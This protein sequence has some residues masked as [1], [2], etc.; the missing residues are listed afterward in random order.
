MACDVA[1]ILSTTMIHKDLILT[2]RDDREKAS[3]NQTHALP[4]TVGGFDLRGDL[5][6]KRSKPENVMAHALN[7]MTHSHGD[8]GVQSS[9]PTP[10]TM[11]TV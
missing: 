11:R 3:T 6:S 5:A 4:K 8:T 2:R 9:T 10:I 1:Q 7:L